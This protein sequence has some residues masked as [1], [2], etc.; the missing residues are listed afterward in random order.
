L[1]PDRLTAG[2][3]DSIKID[4]DS[5]GILGITEFLAPAASTM[6]DHLQVSSILESI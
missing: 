3:E 5:F 1:I 6:A 2:R 4:E